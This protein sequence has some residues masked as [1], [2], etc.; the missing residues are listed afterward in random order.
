MYSKGISWVLIYMP[1]T[2]DSKAKVTNKFLYLKKSSFRDYMKS[3]K[4]QRDRCCRKKNVHSALGTEERTASLGGWSP[5]GVSQGCGEGCT[6]CVKGRAPRSRVGWEAPGLRLAAWGQ[7]GK[8]RC[9]RTKGC[10]LCVRNQNE[11]P[12]RPFPTP[13]FYCLKNLK[14]WWNIFFKKLTYGVAQGIGHRP[15][16]M[17][18]STPSQG[19][20]LG[21]GSGPQCGALQRQPH[22]DVSL[23]LVLLPFPSV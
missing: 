20:C 10:L 4:V 2:E 21:C 23:P 9:Y 7:V 14:D 18:G 3:N 15:G 1:D 16:S 12:Q 22:T 19:T 8:Q 11:W 17:A 5:R 6:V 13:V